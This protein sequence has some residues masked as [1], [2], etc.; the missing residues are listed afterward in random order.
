M[1]EAISLNLVFEIEL[2]CMCFML[3]A[4]HS[5][6]TIHLW[7]LLTCCCHEIQVR[8]YEFLSVMVSLTNWSYLGLAFIMACILAFVYLLA[9]ISVTLFPLSFLR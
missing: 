8:K 9:F 4:L 7:L 5:G 3:L 1:F 6:E 2:V